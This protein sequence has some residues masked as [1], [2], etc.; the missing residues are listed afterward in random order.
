MSSNMAFEGFKEYLGYEANR[1]ILNVFEKINNSE[2]KFP[3]N[4]TLKQ[5]CISQEQLAQKNKSRF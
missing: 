4:Y 1:A 2:K 5:K 3:I